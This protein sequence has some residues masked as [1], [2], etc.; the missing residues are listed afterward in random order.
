MMHRAM[1]D[2]SLRQHKRDPK[3]NHRHGVR[4]RPAMPQIRQ[5][6]PRHVSRE[7]DAE[8]EG[9]NEHLFFLLLLLLRSREW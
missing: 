6:A 5:I 3:C 2:T 1:L 7:V 9:Q 4:A 8:L